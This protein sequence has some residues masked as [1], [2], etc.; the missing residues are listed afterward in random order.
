MLKKRSNGN[1]LTGDGQVHHAEE[2][3]PIIATIKTMPRWLSRHSTRFVIERS[4][5]QV[6]PG[7]F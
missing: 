6:Q 4:L 1:I 5:V 3:G 7:A 2:Y